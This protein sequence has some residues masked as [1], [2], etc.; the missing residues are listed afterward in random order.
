MQLLY[1]LIEIIVKCVVVFAGLMIVVAYL[2]W[3]ER[4]V[5]GH[6]QIRYGPNRCGPFGLLQ[7]FSDAVKAF[8]KEDLVPERSDKVIFVMAPMISII[9]A[10]AFSLSSRLAISLP[11]LERIGWSNCG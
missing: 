2:T 11:S 10:S 3:L 4:K 9:A 8:F 5:L 1:L 6:I 7:P